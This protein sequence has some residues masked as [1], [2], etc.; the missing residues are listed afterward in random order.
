MKY[1]DFRD[2]FFNALTQLRPVEERLPFFPEGR[3]KRILQRL[4]YG[5][6]KAF[7]NFLLFFALPVV[8]ILGLYVTWLQ[9]RGMF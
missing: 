4:E 8:F 6:D 3:V 9:I 2:W 7:I 1:A 5:I